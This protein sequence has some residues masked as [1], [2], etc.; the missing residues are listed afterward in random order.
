[1]CLKVCLQCIWLEEGLEVAGNGIDL[2]GCQRTWGCSFEEV[3]KEI[4]PQD[5]ECTA[6]VRRNRDRGVWKYHDGLHEYLNIR[7]GFNLLAEIQCPSKDSLAVTRMIVFTINGDHA[8]TR[9]RDHAFPV[10]GLQGKDPCRANNNMVNVPAYAW[11]GEIMEDGIGVR[12]IGN[13]IS[14]KRLTFTTLAEC[15]P[16]IQHPVSIARYIATREVNRKKHR[17][18]YKRHNQ[19]VRRLPKPKPMLQPYQIEG[20]C[21]CD[22][23]S[24]HEAEEL[25][26]SFSKHEIS[27]DTKSLSHIVEAS[28]LLN[29][30]ALRL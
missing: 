10:L 26:S 19:T 22:N 16:C 6:S 23:Q 5:R 18:D 1:M 24:E 12:E 14:R 28:L 9:E 13:S 11:M 17:T 30:H 25:T 21:N 20:C 29:K 3:L 2:L 7:K 8:L 4:K 15:D 27:W